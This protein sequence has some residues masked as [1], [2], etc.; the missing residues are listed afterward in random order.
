MSCPACFGAGCEFCTALADTWPPGLFG[1]MTMGPGLPTEPE[2][3]PATRVCPRCKSVGR[4]ERT[5][6]VWFCRLCGKEERA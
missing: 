3:D 6:D 2:V 4:M 1:G 5:K